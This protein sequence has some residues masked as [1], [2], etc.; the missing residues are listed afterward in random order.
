MFQIL[1][2]GDKITLPKLVKSDDIKTP[3]KPSPV[4]QNG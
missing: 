3:K 4:V 1:R 2:G